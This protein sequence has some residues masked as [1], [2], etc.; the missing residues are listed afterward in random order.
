MGKTQMYDWIDECVNPLAGECQHKC[1]YCY[2]NSLKKRFPKIRE[3][4]TGESRI[5]EKGLDL[6]KGSG[7]T[8]FVGS[9]NDLFAEN[10]LKKLIHTILD[11]CWKYQDNTYLFQTKNPVR[12]YEFLLRFPLKSILAIT[13]EGT[14]FAE[15]SKAPLPSERIL[16]LY[17]LAP[18]IHHRPR[19]PAIM[20]SIEPV[21]IWRDCEN[22]FGLIKAIRPDIV[23]IGANT[24]N[25]KIPEPTADEL[26]DLIA[27][28]R[29]ITPDVCLKHN[30]NR[31]L[32][33]EKLMELQAEIAKK[34]AVNDG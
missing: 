3:K 33:E 20:I 10:V 14:W 2:M 15:L 7:K 4:Y 22:A 16:E 25:V 21:T 6:I 11:R 24:S 17:R 31:I 23:S 12:L 30:L 29:Q 18:Q 8:I 19:P 13:I 26:V 32:G 9:S 34:G 1:V 27:Q 28:M 5:D